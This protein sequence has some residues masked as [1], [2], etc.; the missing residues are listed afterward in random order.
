ME[1]GHDDP[2]HGSPLQ[3][4]SEDPLPGG[5]RGVE[6][7]ARIDDGPA[8]AVREQPQID[9][10]G[11][12]GQAHAHPVQAGCDLQRGAVRRA[13]GERVVERRAIRA[14]V[15]V[16]SARAIARQPMSRRQ[17]PPGQS[18]RSIAA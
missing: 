14:H 11:R 6:A 2:R 10:L 18:M 4:L 17:N 15:P 5:A 12:E 9:V 7:E 1:M 3:P 8:V 16:P 13:F